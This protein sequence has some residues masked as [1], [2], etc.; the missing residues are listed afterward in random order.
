[1]RRRAGGGTGMIGRALTKALVERNHAVVI[2]SRSSKENASAGVT[3]AKW[4]VSAQTI[5]E[6][7]ISSADYI[8][9]LAGAGVA[10]KRWTNKRK[11]EIVESRVMSGELLVN[12]LKNI[13]NDVRA[14]ISASAIGW[15]GPDPMTPNPDPFEEEDP[16]SKDFLGETCMQWERSIMPVEKLQKRLVILRT[17]IVLSAEGGALVEFVKPARF[18][19]ATILGSG[20]QVMSWIDIDDL[21]RLYIDAIEND[22]MSGIYNAVAPRPATNEQIVL[23]AARIIK[24][25]Y[26]I[27]IHVPAFFLRLF[28]GEMSV[29]VLKSATVSCNKL[30]ALNFSFLRPNLETSLTAQLH[31]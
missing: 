29:E 17:G 1:M 23:T 13:P 27:P 9:H 12:S 20:K 11:K 8:I 10:D 28:L 25:K 6:S 5:D 14:V 3:Y 21:V 22:R 31:K 19:L 4:D 18:G 15:Y 7:S 26:Y 16:A 2:L 24:G 30:H